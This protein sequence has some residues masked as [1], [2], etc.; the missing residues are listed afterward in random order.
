MKLNLCFEAFSY[1]PLMCPSCPQGRREI[2]R[3]ID[4]LDPDLLRKMLQRLAPQCTINRITLFNYSEP[5]L[6]K[7]LPQL[8]TIAK[9][10]GRVQVA[11]SGD[12]CSCDLSAL[13][14]S[15]PDDLT[16]TLSGMTPATHQL[17]RPGANWQKTITFLRTM[18][19]LDCRGLC[20]LWHRW[21]HTLAEENCAK[22]FGRR[23][24]V[25]IHYTWGTQ[26]GQ[27]DLIA[28]KSNSH[29]LVSTRDQLAI[30]RREPNYDCPFQVSELGINSNGDVRGC[31]VAAT[32]DIVG[33]VLRDSVDTILARKQRFSL[34]G[35]CYK[36]HAYKLACGMSTGVHRAFA[37]AAGGTWSDKLRWATERLKKRIWS[38]LENPR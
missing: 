36:S 27:E 33:N 34:C 25:P 3:H 37:D 11:T 14:H 20:I 35:P 9:S 16:V 19:S 17:T 5:L 24:G 30:A 2:P 28:A 31:S 22:R 15:Q 12:H 4:S 13:A 18:R 1:C 21:P 8:I 29:Q 6:H 32:Q 10:Y 23:L 38:R 26:L 7:D